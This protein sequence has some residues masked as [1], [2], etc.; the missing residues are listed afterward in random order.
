MPMDD[1][2][3]RGPAIRTPDQRLRVFVSSTL[4]ELAAERRAARAAIEQLRLAPVMFESGAR[5]HPP[6]EVYRAYLE[7]SDIFVGIYWQRYGWVGPGMTIS[8]L[9]DE[10]RLAAGMPRLLYVKV[11]APGME[12]G[13][14]QM[15]EV[16]RA[17]GA[18]AYKRF[19]SAR[20]LRGS[21]R[22]TWR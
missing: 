21:S 5:A 8:G 17:E 2:G 9:E 16:V 4:E 7:Q 12:P 11:P 3:P 15:L 19:S 14:S 22:V 13:L 6:Q 10:L 1:D 20:E 18:T